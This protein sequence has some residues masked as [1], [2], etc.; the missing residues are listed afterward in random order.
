MGY[1]PSLAAT[2]VLQVLE[3]QGVRADDTIFCGPK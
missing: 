1:G 3:K 2:W